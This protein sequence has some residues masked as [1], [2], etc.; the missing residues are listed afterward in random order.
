MTNNVIFKRMLARLFFLFYLVLL[1][2]ACGNDD[3][4]VH[5]TVVGA[6]S[7]QF[8]P[9]VT[10]VP[11]SVKVNLT[12]ENVG[13]L[14]HNFIITKDGT[15][16]SNVSEADALTDINTGIVL[17][18]DKVELTFLAPAPSTYTFV[19]VVPGHAAL[20]MVGTLTITDP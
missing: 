20:G 14:E 16:L 3:N 10:S 4:T 9:D 7:F 2:A 5:L 8:T 11:A 13:D 12:F 1:L 17:G 15:D 6:D 19:C 18:G